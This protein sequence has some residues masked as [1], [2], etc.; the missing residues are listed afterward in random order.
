MVKNTIK[1]KI[2]VKTSK[3]HMTLQETLQQKEKKKKDTTPQ[4]IE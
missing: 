1:G 4:G 2:E 3:Q